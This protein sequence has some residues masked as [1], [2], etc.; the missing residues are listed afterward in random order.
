MAITGRRWIGDEFKGIPASV[1][2]DLRAYPVSRARN[3]AVR[4]SA[5]VR[6][7]QSVAAKPLAGIGKLRRSAKPI[8]RQQKTEA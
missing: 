5:K 7:L 2:A 3:D 8:Y 1:F 6:L 4:I